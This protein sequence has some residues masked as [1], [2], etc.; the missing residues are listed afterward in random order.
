MKIDISKIEF[1][2]DGELEQAIEDNKSPIEKLLD[3][4]ALR[5][6]LQKEQAKRITIKVTTP[7]TK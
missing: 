5:W 7:S 6:A 4:E 3:K 2:T 1:L